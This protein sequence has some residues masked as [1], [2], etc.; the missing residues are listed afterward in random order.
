MLLFRAISVAVAAGSVVAFIISAQDILAV[1]DSATLTGPDSTLKLYCK[2]QPAGIWESDSVGS[3]FRTGL[4][5]ASFSL[6][7][8][9]ATHELGGTVP[10][11][12]GFT[13]LSY[14]RILGKVVGRDQWYR[15]NWELMQELFG[16]MQAHPAKGRYVIGESTLLR[17]N[18]ATGTRWIPFIEA[19]AGLSATDIGRPDLGSVFEFNMQTGSG[20]HY[21]WRSSTALTFQ[22][23][24]THLCNAGIKRPNQGISENMFYVGVSW[25][26]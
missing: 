11:D 2:P 3:G 25:F 26:F 18:F 22:Y 20:V 6:G 15:G 10:H 9:F 16:G 5:A 23:R 13:R 4:R 8:G 19:G 21:F 17:Y 7:G 1:D 24:L 12:V 14:S